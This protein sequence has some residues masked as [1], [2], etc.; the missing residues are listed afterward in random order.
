L[1]VVIWY[2]IVWCICRYFGDVCTLR[3]Q[4]FDNSNIFCWHM[5]I[6][7]YLDFTRLLSNLKCY[8]SI[9]SSLKLISL[10]INT[11]YS[12]LALSSVIEYPI[13]TWQKLHFS[14]TPRLVIQH[15]I[16]YENLKMKSFS[17]TV[18]EIK[19]SG[20]FKIVYSVA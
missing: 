7:M 8:K 5:H 15:Q 18:F 11:R 6:N 13:H 10:Y 1:A 16:R 2:T 20:N 17:F 9:L 4:R 14:W 12:D 3:I 19:N